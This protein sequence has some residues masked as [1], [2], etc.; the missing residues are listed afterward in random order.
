MK[1]EKNIYKGNLFFKICVEV[2]NT[3][4]EN[5]GVHQA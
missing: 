4:L 1:I 2:K 3:F 5:R